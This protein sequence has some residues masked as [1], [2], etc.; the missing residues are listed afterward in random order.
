MTVQTRARLPH[1]IAHFA[2][3]GVKAVCIHQ[4]QM[5]I[6]QFMP[7]KMSRHLEM[8][9]EAMERDA[10]TAGPTRKQDCWWLEHCAHQADRPSSRRCMR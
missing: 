2:W 3:N 6:V 10:I 4:D 9:R 5:R 8:W 1:L 7:D